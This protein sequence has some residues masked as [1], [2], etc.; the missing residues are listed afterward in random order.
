MNPRMIIFDD[1]HG[2]LGPMTDLRASFEV[3]TGMFTTAGRIAAHRPKSLAGYWVAPEKV[4]LLRQRADAPLNELP[5]DELVYCVNGRWGMPDPELQLEVG[6]ALI[7]R[8]TGDVV[9]ALLRHADAEYLLSRSQLHERVAVREHE[10]R[11]LYRYPWDVLA[12]M[13]QTIAQDILSTRI[14]DAK[15]LGEEAAVVGRHP[16]EIHRSAMIFPGVVFDVMNGPVI[17]HESAVIRPGAILC[18]PCSVGRGAMV[19]DRAVIRSNTVIGHRCK[20]GGEVGAT[21]FQGFSNKTH[22]GYLGDSWIGK[23]VNFGAGTNNS[24]LLNTYGEVSMRIEPGEPKHRTGTQ[25]LGAIVG[26]HAKF[27][28]GTR[29]ATGTVVGTG[30]MIACSGLTPTTIRRF[31]W[32][33]DRG[34][35]I[36]RLEKFLETAVEV[37]RRRDKKPTEP[38]LQVLR[39]LH[40]QVIRDRRGGGVA[41]S[42]ERT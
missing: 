36:H 2:Q 30:A 12:L 14:L 16:I 10:Q 17:V 33:T 7:E 3:R 21:I 8:S 4:E 25:F 11:L 18:G 19:M 22:E 27:A 15:V 34:E 20:V 39:E 26:D 31:A 28:I 1:G 5:G 37:M 32:I 41:S 40:G 6:E 13:E 23:W 9:A 42:H 35:Q 38:Y 24:N 29:L